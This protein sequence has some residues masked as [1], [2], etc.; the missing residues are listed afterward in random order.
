MSPTRIARA[1]GLALVLA[2]AAACGGE[3][4]GDHPGHGVVM[5]VDAAAR[6]V[7]LDHE[8]IPGLMKGMTM[9]FDVAPDVSLEGIR[10]GMEVDFRLKHEN[11]V[12][13]VTAL[14]AVQEE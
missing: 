11:G 9:T 3:A 8:D 10:S 5:N 1:A 2:V 7:T 12:Y 4:S 14:S 6:N 13:T